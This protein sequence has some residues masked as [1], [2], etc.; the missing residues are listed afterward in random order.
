MATT[1][2][3][4]IGLDGQTV[5][6]L[7]TSTIPVIVD[8]ET[9]RAAKSQATLGSL[10]NLGNNSESE[11][12]VTVGSICLG[13]GLPPVPAKLVKKIRRGD[14]IK[15]YEL[16]PD[17]WLQADD[18]EAGTHSGKYCRVMDVKVWAQC[19]ASYI[20]V[21]AVNEP[22]R[23]ADL[24]GYMINI[25]R[26]SQDFEGSA[27]VTYDDTFRRQ[28]ANNKEKIW[29]NINTFLFLLFHKQ[30]PNQQEV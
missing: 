24:L 22:E 5:N 11:K 25:I 20:R 28:A 19:F 4:S 18:R 14:F 27:W 16:L 12:K 6:Q 7:D 30:S 9:R 29:S 8:A 10:L 13:E 17:L 2:T 21:V 3:P 1:Q 15:M 26:A 23:V